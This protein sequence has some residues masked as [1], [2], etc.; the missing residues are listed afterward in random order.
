MSEQK[1][2]GKKPLS[3]TKQVLPEPEKP[4]DRKDK[5]KEKAEIPEESDDESFVEDDSDDDDDSDDEFTSEEEEEQLIQDELA[6]LFDEAEQNGDKSDYQ[7]GLRS[8]AIKQKRPLQDAKV[9]SASG[10]SKKPKSEK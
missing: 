4:V 6:E 1:D 7:V 2:K 9:G 8:G 10:I 3:P 5:G